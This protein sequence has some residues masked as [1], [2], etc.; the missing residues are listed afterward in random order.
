MIERAF[1]LLPLLELAENLPDPRTDVPLRN[2]R[3]GLKGEIVE[4]T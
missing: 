4:L 2:S 1:V 3:E